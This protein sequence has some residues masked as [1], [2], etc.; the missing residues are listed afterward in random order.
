VNQSVPERLL[1]IGTVDYDTAGDDGSRFRMVGLPNPDALVRLVDRAQR[2][3]FDRDRERTA[4]AEAEADHQIR[5]RRAP[6]DDDL[7]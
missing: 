6:A 1:R 3:A 5:T 7:R 4:R 2:D